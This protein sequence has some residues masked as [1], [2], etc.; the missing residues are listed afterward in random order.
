MTGVADKWVPAGTSLGQAMAEFMVETGGPGLTDITGRLARWLVEIGADDGLLTVFI[1]HTSASL[2]VQENAD[3]DV[4]ADL[5]DALSGLAPAE[6]PYRHHLEGPDD[7][8]AHIKAMLT[9]TSVAIP[10][11]AGRMR[12]GTWQAVYVIEH[13]AKGYRRSLALH[14]LGTGRS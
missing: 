14:F 3:P 12:L 7:M 11:T 8:P 9:A 2:T 13:R 5:V 6:A 10:V 1:R 4:Q